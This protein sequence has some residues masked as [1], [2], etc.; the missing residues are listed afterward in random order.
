[1]FHFCLFSLILLLLCRVYRRG[2]R[3]Y[4]TVW[5]RIYKG[6][7]AW[8]LRPGGGQ[9]F[10]LPSDTTQYREGRAAPGPPTEARLYIYTTIK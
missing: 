6:F 9:A 2:M 5:A 3:R 7:A 10:P 4:L 8:L 1:M